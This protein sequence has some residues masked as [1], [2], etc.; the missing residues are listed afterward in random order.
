MDYNTKF[1]QSQYIEIMD[2]NFIAAEIAK[3]NKGEQ[4]AI[5]FYYRLLSDTQ[6]LPPEFCADIREILSDEMN[7]SKVLSEWV[8]KL[9]GVVP[10]TT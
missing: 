5:E 9:T 7:H 3:N 4:E 6:G 2:I 8:T 10:A 1:P